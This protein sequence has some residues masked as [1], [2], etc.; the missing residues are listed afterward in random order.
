[1]SVSRMSRTNRPVSPTGSGVFVTG[2]HRRRARPYGALDVPDVDP[3]ECTLRV[4][5]G[6]RADGRVTLL[7]AALAQQLL[8]YLDGRTRGP[9]FTSTGGTRFSVRRIRSVLHGAAQRAGIHPK[10]MSLHTVRSTW[11]TL[12]WNAGMP[13]ET[14][15]ALMGHAGPRLFRGCSAVTVYTARADYERAM[16][17]IAA[18]PDGGAL[19]GAHHAG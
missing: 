4:R 9:L 17:A 18:A 8:V 5:R 15:R 13:I 14:V 1:M 2:D 7:T 6:R 19:M 12:A 11:A 10:T 16:S 3:V